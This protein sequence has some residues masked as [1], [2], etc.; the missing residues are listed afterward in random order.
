MKRIAFL[1]LFLLLILFCINADVLAQGCVQCRMGPS[2]NLESGGNVA[3][4]INSGILYLMLIPY[5]LIMSI[6]GYVFR[7]QINGKWT[8][9]KDYFN[10]KALTH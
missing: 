1:S 6:V 2:S 4:G 3:R 10:R 5:L 7:K 9:I 8:L